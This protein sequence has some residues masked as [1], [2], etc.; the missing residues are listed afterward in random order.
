MF[1]PRSLEL[2]QEID[3]ILKQIISTLREDKPELGPAV[4][5]SFRKVKAIRSYHSVTSSM[6][7]DSR[8][9]ALDYAVSQHIVPLLNGYGQKFGKRLGLLLDV[10]PDEMEI[11]HQML[12]RIIDTGNQN[13]YTY[14]FNL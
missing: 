2:P 3:I 7:I 11:T 13:M 12:K 10:I 8:F 6:Y 9:K 1:T 14:G 4:S 5:I